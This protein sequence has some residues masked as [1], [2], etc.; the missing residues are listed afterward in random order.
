MLF[1]LGCCWLFRSAGELL[2]VDERPAAPQDIAFV[3]MGGDSGRIVMAAQLYQQK[4]VRKVMFVSTEFEP[5][6][7]PSIGYQYSSLAT[8]YLQQLGVPAA[9]IVVLQD[10][11]AASTRDEALS[12]RTYW[13][14]HPDLQ[15][16]ILVTSWFHSSRSH[17][18][19]ER[20]LADSPQLAQRLTTSLYMVAA[21]TPGTGPA[22]WW[23]SERYFLAVFNEYVKW[24]YYR[25]HY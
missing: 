3:L 2:V 10:R 22:T 15:G 12:L 16:V 19:V 8:A 5:F 1:V 9:D 21:P 13:E 23:R 20:V 11:Q 25:L 17:W 24:L 18:I 14:Q 6:G 4:Q 7:D